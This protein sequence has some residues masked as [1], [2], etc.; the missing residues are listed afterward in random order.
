MTLVEGVS[1]DPSPVSPSNDLGPWAG[2]RV[3]VNE[4]TPVF[5]RSLEPTLC[6]D[7]LSV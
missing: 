6:S 7:F 4:P 5:H 1:V 3:M 2:P